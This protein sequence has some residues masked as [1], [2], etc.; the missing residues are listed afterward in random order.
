MHPKQQNPENAQTELSWRNRLED[1]DAEAWRSLLY[2]LLPMAMQKLREAFGAYDLIRR[3]DGDEIATQAALWSAWTSFQSHFVNG[4]FKDARDLE[5]L[6]VHFIRIAYNRWQ[7][8]DRR[9]QKL[10]VAVGRGT[11]RDTNGQRHTREF[12][13]SYPSPDEQVAM[14]DLAAHLDALVD[15]V[16]EEFPGQKQRIIHLWLSGLRDGSG[17]RQDKIATELNI[18]QSTVSR[19]LTQFFDRLRAL[20]DERGQE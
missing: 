1:S 3:L 6:A 11:V 9:Q 14:A 2:R 19:S 20:L 7:R 17:P 5:T 13:D 12:P 15:K 10:D 16:K 8:D 4:E 18:N